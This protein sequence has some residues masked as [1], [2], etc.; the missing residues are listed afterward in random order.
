MLLERNETEFGFEG[1]Q[2]RE[3][4]SRKGVVERIR[5]DIFVMCGKVSKPKGP[6]YD[7]VSEFSE[8]YTLASESGKSSH[9]FATAAMLHFGTGGARQSSRLALQWYLAAGASGGDKMDRWKALNNCGVMYA[10]GTG[11]LKID[12]EFALEI[13]SLVEYEMSLGTTPGLK[14]SQVSWHCALNLGNLRGLKE[15]NRLRD[16]AESRNRL[17]KV[18]EHYSDYIAM[19]NLACLYLEEGNMTLAKRWLQRGICEGF[20]IANEACIH[21]LKVFCFLGCEGG[22]SWTIENEEEDFDI[23]EYRHAKVLEELPKHP[24][25]FVFIKAYRVCRV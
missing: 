9:A 10:L 17:S 24:C 25:D 22:K 18:A 14:G 7:R 1:Q 23:V 21:N 16:H 13:W 2:T 12:L 15:S 3:V 20:T 4:E 8:V 19:N 6:R 11:K 5:N